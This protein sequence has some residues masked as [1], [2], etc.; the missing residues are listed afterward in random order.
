MARMNRLTW[1]SIDGG[2]FADIDE[3]EIIE[4]DGSPA[5][6]G[7]MVDRLAAYEDTGLTPEEIASLQAKNAALR[8]KLEQERA[9]K[10]A[11]IADLNEMA[12]CEVCVYASSNVNDRPCKDCNGDLFDWRGAEGREGEG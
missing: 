10:E 12:P 2:F 11:A 7:D 5:L 8:A 9:E 4:F 6:Y 1:E 3:N